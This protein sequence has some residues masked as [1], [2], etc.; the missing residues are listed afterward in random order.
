MACV[1]PVHEA[2]SVV[3]TR[4]YATNTKEALFLLSRGN[5]YEP[6]C[7]N[8][9]MEWT[10]NE[11]VL[12]AEVAHIRGLN[13]GSR[14]Y[15]ASV[16]GPERNNFKNLLL[17]CEKHHKLVDGSRTWR[18]YP[19]ET[20]TKWKEER[21]G[22]LA[23]EL[24]QLDWITQETLHDLMAEAIEDTQ[25]RILEAIDGIS[26]IS[27]ETLATLRALVAETLK[28][29][30]LNPED[31]ASLERS[32]GVLQVVIPEYVP[33]LSRSAQTLAQVIEYSVILERA[34]I[35]L[36]NLADYAEMLRHAVSP[37][38]DLETVIPQLRSA[39]EAVSGSAVWDYQNAA[40]EISDAAERINGSVHSL[41]LAAIPAAVSSYE[42]P[43]TAVRVVRAAAGRW[44]WS[45]FWWGAAVCMACVITVLSLWAYAA[46]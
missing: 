3:V 34:S 46:G 26:T 20:L 42:E 23:G 11:W 28:L 12:L 35:Q 7:K 44:S 15:D 33:Q 24:G 37:L 22:N 17:L 43:V 5:C 1:C 13:E 18:D 8:R 25:S 10:G 19:V 36:V 14:R 39:S 40:R 41:S 32:A 4:S 45:T 2:R 29:P 6:K 38:K 27:G 9:V 30:Y 21:E 16:P 31:V